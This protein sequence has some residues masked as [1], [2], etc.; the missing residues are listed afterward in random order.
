MRYLLLVASALCFKAIC[1]AQ[2]PGQL[3]R[4]GVKLHDEGRYLEAIAKYDSAIAI[5]ADTYLAYYEKALSLMAAGE[6]EECIR[7]AESALRR[8]PDRSDNSG[9]Y[10]SYGNSYDMLK[11]P[12]KALDVYDEGIKRFPRASLLYFNKAITLSNMGKKAEAEKQVELA[13]RYNPGH[14]SSHRTLSILQKDKN[15]IYSLL[16]SLYFMAIEPTGKRA[17]ERLQEIEKLMGANVEKKEGKG[18]NITL[19][20]AKDGSENEPNNFHSLELAVSMAVALGYE[21]KFRD[22]PRPAKMQRILGVM[23]ER[24]GNNQQKGIGFGWEFYAPFFVELKKKDYV[25]VFCHAMYATSGDEDNIQWIRKNE[26]KVDGYL[27]WVSSY[28]KE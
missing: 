22:E 7:T 19:P 12:G 4:Q 15:R 14:A 17:A 3:V 28:G 21:E 20:A 2:D 10:V 1:L 16:A 13:I 26:K 23:I 24:L 8:F 25:E 11:N 5:N 18:V 6:Y 9:L 27:E